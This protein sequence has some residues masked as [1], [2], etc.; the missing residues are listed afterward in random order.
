M[1]ARSEVRR[2]ECAHARLDRQRVAVPPLDAPRL[3]TVVSTEEEFDWSGPFR[4][5]HTSVESIR[6]LDRA[7]QVFDEFAVKPT[8]VVDYPIATNPLSVA[9][10]AAI[11]AEGKC[12]IGAHLHPWVTPPYDEVVNARNSFPGNLARALERDKLVRLSQAIQSAFGVTP[13]SYQA[14][15]YGFGD[16]TAELLEELGFEIDLSASPGFDYSGEGG[17][18]YLALPS[19]TFWFGRGRPLLAVPMSGGVIGHLPRGRQWLYKT[20]SSRRVRWAPV[21]PAIARLRLV[22]RVRLSSEGFDHSS[23]MRLVDSLFDEGVRIFAFGLHS[24]SFAPGYTPYSS[25]P[26]QLDALFD[27][28]RRF[29]RFFLTER[30]GRHLTSSELRSELLVRCPPQR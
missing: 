2:A 17:P 22:E 25:G 29:Y 15:R 10:I 7:Q 1:D 21:L 5:Q 23:L 9:R 14:G 11:H 27:Q 16:H 20:A 28:I 3:I 8:Y 6:G 12:E 4:R 18:N 19:D 13:R 30:G 24:P 26:K